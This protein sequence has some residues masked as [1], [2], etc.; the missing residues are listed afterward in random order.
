MIPF[1]AA[2]SLGGTLTP[3]PLG[4]LGVP[5]K[6]GLTVFLYRVPAHRCFLCPHVVVGLPVSLSR[7]GGARPCLGSIWPREQ[8][9]DDHKYLFDR[10]LGLHTQPMLFP[11][12]A[13]ADATAAFLHPNHSLRYTLQN[14]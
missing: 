9:S 10:F 13:L 11:S 2:R 7:S 14:V 8:P 5:V 12:E 3:C 6:L 1:L 4:H